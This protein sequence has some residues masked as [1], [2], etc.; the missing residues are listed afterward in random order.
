MT[1]KM[2]WWRRRENAN[3]LLLNSFLQ[4]ES[5]RLRARSDLEAKRDELEVRKLE[6]ELSHLEARTKAQIELEAAQQELR[7]K[8]REAARKGMQKRRALTGQP[9]AQYPDCGLCVDPARRDVTVEMVRQHN[10]HSFV[11]LNAPV[12]QSG[13]NGNGM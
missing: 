8:K 1:R 9:P 11:A 13:A 7:I 2:A 6:V 4:L 12:E 3:Q 5:E 10:L